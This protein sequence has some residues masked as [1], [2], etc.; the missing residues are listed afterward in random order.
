MKGKKEACL[1]AGMDD[2]VSKPYN[3]QVLLARIAMVLK[4]TKKEVSQDVSFLR[5]KGVVLNL[6]N[7]YVSYG[8]KSIELTKNEMK[9]LHILFQNADKIV[10]RMSMIEYL[11]DS[12]VFIDDNTL[13]VNITRIRNKLESIDVQD[14]I[15]TKRGLG[16]KI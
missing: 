5:H 12:Q 14:F 1:S 3:A 4:R 11:W 9:I 15:E 6:E 7:Y 16:Y 13:S 10:S 2:Y 8:E